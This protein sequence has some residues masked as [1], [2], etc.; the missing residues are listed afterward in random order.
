MHPPPPS[1]PPHEPE[2]E[3]LGRVAHGFLW[4][5]RRALWLAGLCGVGYGLWRC[6]IDEGAANGLWLWLTEAGATWSFRT[7]P[8]AHGVVWLCLGFP[9]LLPVGWTFGRGRWL[10][11]AVSAALWF[12]AMALVEDHRYGF[13]L[14]IVATFVVAATLLVWRTLW[15]LTSAAAAAR[16]VKAS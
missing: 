5:V 2:I 9:A 13:V 10:V 6:W 1:K 4:L 8:S 3:A 16:R 15:R 11:L 7:S 14:R 12:G